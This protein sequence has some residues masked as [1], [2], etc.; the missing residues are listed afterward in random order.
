LLFRVEIVVIAV[1]HT[2]IR[3]P[4]ERCPID[5]VNVA[6]VVTVVDAIGGG[7]I[8]GVNR[9]S[10]AAP[11]VAIAAKWEVQSLILHLEDLFRNALVLVQADRLE[12]VRERLSLAFPG[13][14][15]LAFFPFP[16]VLLFL[17]L[18]EANVRD[19]RDPVADML[20]ASRAASDVASLLY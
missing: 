1:Q 15:S 8:V 3:A 11:D 14:P 4:K 5:V 18:E 9:K 17:Q 6:I 7:S 20:E 10:N 2:G 19:E 16:K 13:S 12:G